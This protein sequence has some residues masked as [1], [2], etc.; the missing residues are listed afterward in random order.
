MVAT[1]LALIASTGVGLIVVP[2]NERVTRPLRAWLDDAGLAG[3]P[4]GAIAL[5]LL[6][7]A[8]V[9]SGLVA[10]LVP[11]PA[12]APLA[13]VAG[14]AIPIA[15]LDAARTRRW[16]VA[17]AAWPD[18]IDSVRMALRSGVALHEAMSAASP[19]VP[20]DWRQ[21]WNRAVTDL[22]RG[23][24]TVDA[25]RLFRASRAD[26]IADRV[27]DSISIAHELGGAE[28]PRVL[29]ELARSIRDEIRLR[30]EASARQSWVRHAARLGSVAPWVVVVLLG[31]RPENRDVFAS[32]AGTALL[33]GCAGATVVAYV[34][35]IAIGR[36]PEPERWVSDG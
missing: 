21:S 7:L 28:L 13:G 27:C 3:I 24:A 32:A 11:I 18:I 29:E 26:P 8:V 9:C 2:S 10:A 35:M 23:T 25:L 16:A 12:L 34:L 31:G 22:A 15:V 1:V 33:V 6:T 14:I 30:R 17:T 4:A 36:L 5:T 19:Q 20:V